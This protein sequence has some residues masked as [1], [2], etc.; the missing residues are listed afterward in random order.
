LETVGRDREKLKG[1]EVDVTGYIL[2][3]IIWWSR[4][5]ARKL[6]WFLWCRIIKM[7]KKGV[8]MIFRPFTYDKMNIGYV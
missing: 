2:A 5:E 8:E 3:Q 1:L 4:N 7:L 6:W